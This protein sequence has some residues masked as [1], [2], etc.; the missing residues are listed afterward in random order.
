MASKTKREYMNLFAPNTGDKKMDEA[1]SRLKTH[2]DK[3]KSFDE[4]LQHFN[5]IVKTDDAELLN[6]WLLKVLYVD[7]KQ[8]STPKHDFD[9]LL[10]RVDEAKR[11]E[12]QNWLNGMLLQVGGD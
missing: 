10:E 1:Y 7:M 5:Y 4:F 6:K 9:K 3:C 12:M 8:D 2:I 11:Q